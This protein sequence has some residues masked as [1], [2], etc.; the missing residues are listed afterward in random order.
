LDGL[1]CGPDMIDHVHGSTGICGAEWYQAEQ[2]PEEYRGCIFLCNPVNGQVHRDR[3]D[4]HGSSP[5]VVTQPEFLTCDDGWFR[6]VDVKLGPDG[7]IYVADFYNCI[8]GHYEVPLDHP[9]RDREH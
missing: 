9:R 5:W 1:G 8:I 3:I 7:A 2:F 4:F 6:P